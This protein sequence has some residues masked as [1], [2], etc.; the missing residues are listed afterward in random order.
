MSDILVKSEWRYP[1]SKKKIKEKVKEILAEAKIKGEVEVSVAVVGDR[2]MKSLN[3]KYRQVEGTTSVLVFPLEGLS[4]SHPELV[5]G[6]IPKQVRN[7]GSFPLPFS[8][9][10][11][12]LRLGDVVISYPQAIKLASQE[13]KLV[14]EKINELVEY[15]L[16]KLLGSNF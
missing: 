1:V 14:D 6:S 13:D 15:G 9:P 5:S 4:V 3:E 16:K 10:D 11:E 7:D 12:V 8:S 2:K